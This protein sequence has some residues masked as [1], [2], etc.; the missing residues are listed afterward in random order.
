MA[1]IQDIELSEDELMMAESMGLES[2]INYDQEDQEE[3]F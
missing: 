1:T 2:F 3:G